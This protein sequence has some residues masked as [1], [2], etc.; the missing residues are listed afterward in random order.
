[1]CLSP[2]VAFVRCR[3]T[4]RKRLLQSRT[5][6]SS[7]E[8]SRCASLRYFCNRSFSPCTLPSQLVK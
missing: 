1:M 7:F 2:N 4:S 3:C 5:C 6:F 8:F